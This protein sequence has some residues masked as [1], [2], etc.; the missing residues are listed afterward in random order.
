MR[1]A[2]PIFLS[3]A[4][5]LG[6]S[7]LAACGTIPDTGASDTAEEEE[8]AQEEPQEETSDEEASETA[9][10]DPTAEEREAAYQ[11][12][13][14]GESVV[15]TFI[16]EPF[17]DGTVQDS[18]DALAAIQSVMD[19]I[20]G[21]ETTVLESVAD[22]PTESGNTYY[23]FRQQAG[24]V[25]VHGASVKLIA[26]AE[27]KAIG[28]VSSIMPNVPIASSYEWGVTQEQ[29]ENA[30]R[31][32]LANDGISGI[33]VLAGASEQTLIA[34]DGNSD[35]A[36]YA[37]TVYTKNYHDEGDAAYL[38]HYVSADGD[39]LY[40]IPVGTPGNTDAQLGERADFDWDALEPSEWTGNVVLHDG[41][42]KELT[43]PVAINEDGEVLLADVERKVLCADYPTYADSNEVYALASLDQ[44]FESVDVLVYSTFLRIWDF[45]DSIGWTGPDGLGTPSLL[46][47]N[48]TDENGDPDPN[49]IYISRANGW[50]AFAFSRVVSFGECTD[51]MAHEFT[52]CVTDT[53]MTTNIYMN[54]MGAINEA[55]SDILGNLV[56]MLLGDSPNG[57]WIHGESGGDA[58]LARSMKDPHQFFQPEYAWDVYYE[59]PV[60]VGNDINDQ[61]G[62]HANSSLLN[63]V[64]YKLDQAGMAPDDQVYYWMNVALAMTPNTD[65]PIMAELLPW[66][67][68]QTG[69][70][71]YKEALAEAI[72]EAKM[73]ATQ[74]DGS[75]PEGAGV[76]ELECPDQE[77]SDSGDFVVYAY[78]DGGKTDI[79]MWPE[80]GES[81]VWL[82]LPEGDYKFV[83]WAKPDDS[84]II[85]AYADGWWV[86]A[87]AIDPQAGPANGTYVHVSAGETIAL[88]TGGLLE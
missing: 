61:G 30:V 27:G 86:P 22:R 26:N 9:E 81:F 44:T 2:T 59:P 35:D 67:L 16:G 14:S 3:L 78:A 83:V 64:S 77:L 70:G 54:D 18:D 32:Q 36:R 73:T 7:G 15:S 8:L 40:S 80:L 69:F 20:G 10:D 62:V 6:T 88:G 41:T 21:D 57:A 72:D 52:H 42:T 38:A 74:S 79:R 12:A 48:L 33:D 87:Y 71:Q 68:E 56:E 84:T 37:W 51:V 55:M 60:A 82:P 13:L 46:L 29:A 85:Y 23:V 75:I 34:L 25:M 43:I 11:R 53:T 4:L 65:Y 19:R 58:T 66:C 76:V 63:L 50:Q 1:R 17:Y 49:A 5:L 39:Y 31:Q 45:Y 28:L 47:M 24:D